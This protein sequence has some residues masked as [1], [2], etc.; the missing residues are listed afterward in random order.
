MAGALSGLFVVG[1]A[2]VSVPLLERVAGYSQ[3][4]AQAMVL[5]MLV[6]ASAIGLVVY[7]S[8]GYVRWGEAC[9]LAG[10]GG[11]GTA[12]RSDST[13]HEAAATEALLCSSARSRWFVAG[14]RSLT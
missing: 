4:R 10:G 9:A 13:G 11:V 8:A 14:H 6:P 7:S 12:W 3:Q 5:V 2:L 1:G